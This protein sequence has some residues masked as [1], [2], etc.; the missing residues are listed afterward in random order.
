MTTKLFEI[1]HGSLIKG[2]VIQNEKDP[3]GTVK[4]VVFDHIDGMYSVCF[5]DGKKDDLLHLAATT[6][7]EQ[8]EDNDAGEGKK[9]PAAFRLNEDDDEG[10]KEP[11]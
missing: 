5:V 1:P 6:P 4:D 10:V 3:K 7:L 11:A 2:L 8:V 9:Y